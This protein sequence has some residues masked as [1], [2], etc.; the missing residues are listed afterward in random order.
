MT[1]ERL[2]RMGLGEIV[3]RG[4][5][6]T[7]RWIERFGIAG[8]PGWGASLRGTGF[9]QSESL[10][11][12]AS[13]RFFEGG[14]D[15]AVAGLL[16][17][18]MPSSCAK[19]LEEADAILQ[20]RFRLLG[21]RDLQIGSPIDWHQDP[22]S[23]RRADIVHYSQLDPL[24][25]VRGATASCCGSSTGTNGSCVWGRPTALRKTTGTPPPS[26]D[27]SSAGWKPTRPEPG[28]TGRAASRWACD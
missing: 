8:R 5:Q 21:H 11:R 4:R 7:T 23:H 12:A 27:I 18:R 9:V 16:M 20:G 19:I 10:R 3:G 14:A 13:V 24:E 1:L 6:Q 22:L 2:T 28:S 25:P 17:E 26:R 15:A